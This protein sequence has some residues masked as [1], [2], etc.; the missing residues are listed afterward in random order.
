M[1]QIAIRQSG[2]ASIVSIPKITLLG[3]CVGSSP[4][5]CAAIR[6]TSLQVT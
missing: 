4:D 1:A 5:R 2:E 6:N 3:L